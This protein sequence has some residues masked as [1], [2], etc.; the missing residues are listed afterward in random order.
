MQNMAIFRCYALNT[1]LR[2]G[3]GLEVSESNFRHELLKYSLV[4]DMAIY[5][6][7]NTL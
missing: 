3:A 6:H 4:L 5:M 1:S 2:D 7:F